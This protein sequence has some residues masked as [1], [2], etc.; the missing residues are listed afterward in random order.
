MSLQPTGVRA[1][2]TAEGDPRVGHLLGRG[3]GD[4]DPA[5]AVLVGFP[6]DDGVVRNRG[7]AG[8]AEGPV[9]LR[10]RLYRLTPDPRVPAFAELLEHTRDLGDIDWQGDL[11]ATQAALGDV[12]A[13]QLQTGALVV[14]LGG[15]HETAYGHF[16]GYAEAGR[17]VCIRNLDAH[18]DVRELRDGLGHS[19]SPFRQ[20]LEHPS[21]ACTDYRVHGLSPSSVSAAH[22][23]YLQD[24]DCRWTFADETDAACV[25]QAYATT[26]EAMYATYCLDVLDQAFAPGVSAPAAHG[27]TPEVWFAA[28][29]AAGAAPHVT[30]M[31]VVELAP[32]YDR[33]GQTARLAALS[34]WTFLRAASQRA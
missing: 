20:A 8:A 10:E 25:Q 30:S 18:A 21:G 33:D 9:A 34:V 4:S 2:E 31:D 5:R 17:S 11:A 1:P 28:V 13:E 16:L 12:V 7:R 27:I 22:L 29:E 14:V 3:L 23:G 26:D 6:V 32:A 15:G 24:H 19:G